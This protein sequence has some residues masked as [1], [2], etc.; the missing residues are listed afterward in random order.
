MLLLPYRGEVIG[1]STAAIA[2]DAVTNAKLAN[3]AANTVKVRD[4]NS[5]GD[6]SDKAVAD[7]HDTYW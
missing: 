7:T 2:D 1:A 3:M 6:A 5:S 4:A